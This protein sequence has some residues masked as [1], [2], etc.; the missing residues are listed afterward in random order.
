M[1]YINGGGLNLEWFRETFCPG[2]SFDDL[3]KVIEGIPPGS[4]G[5]IFNPHLEGRAYP[6]NPAMR[7]EWKGFT[8]GH[9]LG[10]FFKSILEGIAYE[11]ALYMERIL[12]ALGD[13][14]KYTVRGVGGGSKSRVWNQIKADVLNCEYTT[15]NRK[16]ISTLGQAL[17]AASA[18]GAIR[19]I[20]E[21][22]KNIIRVEETFYPDEKNHAVYL[23]FIDRYRRMLLSY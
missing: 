10:H 16:D 3:N 17:I 7:G 22:V 5:L 15:I 2:Y 19:D 23:D 1:S 9:G 4:N 14:R 6:N 21:T 13:K 11:Y 8:R 20:K 18:T 12:E